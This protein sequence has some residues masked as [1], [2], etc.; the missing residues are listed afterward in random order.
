MKREDKEN[1][2]NRDQQERQEGETG[3]RENRLGQGASWMAEEDRLQAEEDSENQAEEEIRL[4]ALEDEALG[5]LHQEPSWK[6]VEEA[7]RMDQR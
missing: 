4:W 7:P 2:Q 3:Q 1:E 5:L 6:K